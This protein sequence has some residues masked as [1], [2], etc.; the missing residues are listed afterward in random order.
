MR[1]SRRLTRLSGLHPVC[2]EV[3]TRMAEGVDA[4]FG[5]LAVLDET[6]VTPQLVIRATYGYSSL[7]V[8]HVR[9]DPGAGIIGQVFET[10][11]PMLAN[12]ADE[13]FR[14]A[15]R[16]RYE[17]D[18][19]V[20]VPLRSRGQVIG[21]VCAADPLDRRPFTRR[22]VAFLEALAAP[23]ATALDLERAI[24]TADA[25]AEA[26]AIDPTSGL[27]NRRYFQIRFE[28]ELQRSRRHDVPVT[29]LIADVDD[30]KMINDLH[31]HLAGDSVIRDI[32]E[33]LR[34]SIR[35]FDVCA[36]FGGEEFAIIMPASGADA[37]VKSA[38][39]I[40]DQIAAYR[41]ADPALSNLSI[42]VSIGVATSTPASSALDLIQQADEA[43]YDAKRAG[44]NRVSF[45]ARTR[46]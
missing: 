4:S 25:Y 18:Q 37:A 42:T 12:A 27:F 2:E 10:G 36:R 40:R 41:S 38:E 44:K 26:A 43:L 29:L 20:A 16:L 6:G 7:L 24:T 33:I 11:R 8:E 34:A 22:D 35:V 9:I 28:E 46:Q 15:H 14:L 32:A 19:F 23:A 45:S 3:L 31:G 13:S 39:R 5:N 21:V 1:L 30:F 17:S